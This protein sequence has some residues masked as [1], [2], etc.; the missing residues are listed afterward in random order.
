MLRNCR[1]SIL[2]LEERYGICVLWRHLRQKPKLFLLNLLALSN[3]LGV[4]QC[5]THCL[6]CVWKDFDALLLRN[7]PPAYWQSQCQ[8]W[9]LLGPLCPCREN[10]T[11]EGRQSSGFVQTSILEHDMSSLRFA[12]SCLCF[13][14]SLRTLKTPWYF[15]A[16]AWESMAAHW[17]GS[18]PMKYSS[19]NHVFVVERKGARGRV[20]RSS[21]RSREEERSCLA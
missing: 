7:T 8:T 16:H 11:R 10:R 21:S 17:K 1:S 2:S 13:L 5:M 18:R 19:W 6:L 9:F 4:L 3:H 20:G 12:K 14:C 15:L